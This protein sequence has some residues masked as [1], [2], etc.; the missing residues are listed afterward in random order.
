MRCYF[1]SFEDLTD[2]EPEPGWYVRGPGDMPP[3]GPFLSKR[4]AEC[5]WYGTD[6]YD[7]E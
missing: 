1:V 5:D 6:G 2:G 7:D 3:I 4:E